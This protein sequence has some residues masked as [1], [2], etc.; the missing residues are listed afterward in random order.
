[1]ISRI[2]VW[3]CWY[4]DLYEAPLST[5]CT[6]EHYIGWYNLSHLRWEVGGSILSGVSPH[7]G[8]CFKSPC[9]TST[10]LV[11]QGTWVGKVVMVCFISTKNKKIKN[12]LQTGKTKSSSPFEDLWEGEFFGP[13]KRKWQQMWYFQ[14]KRKWKS[15]EHG[16]FYLHC[17]CLF[18]RIWSTKF[19][20][21]F[22]SA[23][24]FG[25]WKTKIP[26]LDHPPLLICSPPFHPPFLGQ[27]I[28]LGLPCCTSH[29]YP[30]L[31]H[32]MTIAMFVYNLSLQLH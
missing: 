26:Q 12:C 20:K 24:E 4:E 13:W 2:R 1:M 15:K 6:T 5:V 25:K 8:S 16:T 31:R 32:W 21:L 3:H 28:L 14:W 29:H 30:P 11:C 17:M 7:Y 18:A 9:S 10:R 23:I 22:I 19:L 27:Y